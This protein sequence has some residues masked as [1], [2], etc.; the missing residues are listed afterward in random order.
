MH[1]CMSI[2]IHTHITT[3]V[4]NYMYI[5][6]SDWPERSLEIFHMM[7]QKNP[8]KLFGQP[9]TYS[10]NM[11]WIVPR[12]IPWSRNPQY[13]RMFRDRV[14]TEVIMLKWSFEGWALM[15]YDKCPYK[16]RALG[17]RH[18]QKKDNMKTQGEAGHPQAM[19][20]GLGQIPPESPHKEPLWS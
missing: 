4:Y 20:G 15:Q 14:Y 11:G 19:E 13:F 5:V 8:N 2:Y 16:K 18:V 12:F 6:F 10:I 7:L 17:H 3:P 9:R 1:I